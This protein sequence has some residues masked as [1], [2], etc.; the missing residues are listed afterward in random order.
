[1]VQYAYGDRGYPPI[2]P[3]KATLLYEIELL[4]FT[5]VG[6]TEKLLR[7][8]RETDPHALMNQSKLYKSIKHIVSIVFVSFLW[9]ECE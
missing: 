7:E 4:T 1:M 5:S 2:V 9:K 3:P 8:K 6:N